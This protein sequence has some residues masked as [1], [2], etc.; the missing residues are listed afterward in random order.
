CTE[1]N[2]G[3]Y[4]LDV[5]TL[6]VSILV[7]PCRRTTDPSLD[8]QGV[9][10]FFSVDGFLA[11]AFSH[12]E[13]RD[14]QVQ[15][16]CFVA[17]C[18]NN[19]AIGFAEAGT[20]TGKTFAYLVPLLMRM[21]ERNE[22]VVVATH[23]IH[24]QEQIMRKD[25]PILQK[26]MPTPFK[27]VLVKGRSN[28][29]CLRKLF[30]DEEQGL[31]SF[32]DEQR[33]VLDELRAWSRKTD[34]GSLSDLPTLPA[35]VLWERIA[36]EH[37]NC[38]GSQCHYY[39][40]CFFHRARRRAQQADVLVVN[41]HILCSDGF[42]RVEEGREKEGTLL[43]DYKI[44]IFDEAHNL[45]D[46]ITSYH[47]IEISRYTCL[48][49]LR[50]ILATGKKKNDDGLLTSVKRVIKK[51][52]AEEYRAIITLE[53]FVR[54]A[55][56]R[57]ESFFSAATQRLGPLCEGRTRSVDSS[58][59]REI[60]ALVQEGSDPVDVIDAMRQTARGLI[61]VAEGIQKKKEEKEKSAVDS[62]VL[63]LQAQAVKCEQYAMMMN[64]FFSSIEEAHDRV[65]WLEMK[66]EGR[67]GDVLIFC[68]APVA[69]DSMVNAILVPHERT[70]LF[71]SATL[72]VGG[73]FKYIQERLG[74]RGEEVMA[75]GR[76]TQE[77]VLSSSFDFEQ[78]V[79][80]GV[81]SD[82]EEPQHCDYEM[83]SVHC[84]SEL[85]ERLEGKAFV[86]FTSY[87]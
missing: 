49:L 74:L 55:I 70:A 60:H 51:N 41:H 66:R 15:L 33:G 45:E 85:L 26:I 36:S 40:E 50:R 1:K 72:T 56:Q 10:D 53:D 5:N 57:V 14:E 69:I 82:M 24:L 35:P 63:M 44:I 71:I 61:A 29:V 76:T 59:A 78:N 23:T 62:L 46:A 25:I 13:Y 16:A 39:R 20:G 6:R 27:A 7:K 87:A 81:F 42:S 58:I 67:Y 3:L 75:L 12:Y 17:S 65:S 84:V 86:L 9:K 19:E 37:G 28:Y 11:K 47:T 43:P 83:K 18:M 52:H 31:F 48:K 73:S 22:R 2:V 68:S 79:L 64:S 8:I 21:R 30:F 80:V 32:A 54:R 4:V 34:D 38:M 77:V